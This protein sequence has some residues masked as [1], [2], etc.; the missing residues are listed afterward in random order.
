MRNLLLA[1]ATLTVLTS[2]SAFF[3][4][5]AEV[6]PELAGASFYALE[7]DDIAG[8]PRAL[9]EW[10][11]QVAL[12]VNTASRCGFTPQYSDL[13][14]VYEEY[15]D[16]GFVVLAFPSNDF[17]GQEPGTAEEISA[18]CSDKYGVTFPVFAKVVTGDGAEQSPIYAHLG[19]ST[20][21]L[22]GWNFGK[23]LIARDGSVIGFWDSR[24]N[25]SGDELRAAIE[26]ALSA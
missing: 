25:P 7:A 3:E 9:S 11:G 4:D 12:V 26:A 10:D 21:S 18:F 23:Y 16:Q 14:Q 13:Q 6:D 24:A 17:G 1:T 19:A 15:G 2:C 5:T 20:G 8:E 22:P